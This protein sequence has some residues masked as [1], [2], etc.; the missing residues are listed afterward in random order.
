MYLRGIKMNYENVSLSK[1]LNICDW[2]VKLVFLNFLWIVFSLMGLVVFGVFPATI[3]LL[4]VMRGLIRGEEKKV[5]YCFW[6]SFSKEIVKTNLYGWLVTVPML[7]IFIAIE[8]INGVVNPYIGFI[9]KVGFFIMLIAC[10]Y[11]PFVYIQYK[12]KL[13]EY[14][15]LSYILTFTSP[16]VTILMM[17][18][19]F[20]CY[21]LFVNIPGL[22][23]FFLVS[24]P[25]YL[26]LKIFLILAEKIQNGD[27]TIK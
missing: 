17:L 6:N 22:I 26:T 11:L 16:H 20:I 1:A 5:L 21:I 9:P 18:S 7:L 25:M 10:F 2:I 12:L 8:S 4:T 24:L 19:I 3:A 15:K 23:P 13:V 14:L 27:N